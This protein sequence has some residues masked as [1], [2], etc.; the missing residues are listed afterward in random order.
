LFDAP[1][2]FSIRLGTPGAEPVFVR[3]RLGQL[4]W[5]VTALYY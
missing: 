3:M 4:G 1:L 2:D 5:R